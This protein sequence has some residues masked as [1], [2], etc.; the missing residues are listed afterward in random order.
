MKVHKMLA[1]KGDKV[2]TVRA[3][4]TIATASEILKKERIGALI[5]SDDGIK[6]QGILSE[7][8]IVRGLVSHGEGLLNMRVAQLMTSDVKTCTLDDNIQ[9]VMS[10]MTRGRIRHLPVVDENKLCGMISIGDV[11]KNRLE[12][13]EAETTVL[14]DYIAGRA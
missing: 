8:D 3:D 11:V 14:R 12:E 10:A 1:G 4:T 5:V 7:R 13:L 2:M 6:M 9:E